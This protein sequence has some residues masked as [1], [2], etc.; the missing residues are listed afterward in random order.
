MSYAR[1]ILASRAFLSRPAHASPT[2]LFETVFTLGERDARFIL[3]KKI[4][5]NEPIDRSKRHAA[6]S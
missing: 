6:L 4:A 1:D 5:S 3:G 2:F